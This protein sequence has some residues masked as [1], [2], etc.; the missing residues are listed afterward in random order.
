MVDVTSVLSALVALAAAFS[1]MTGLFV[2]EGF[3]RNKL[4][5]LFDDTSYLIFFF[6]VSGYF[7]YGLGEV[8]Y[9]LISSVLSEAGYFGVQDL[10]WLGGGIMILLSFI[11]LS[12]TFAKRNMRW[13]KFM[14][15][16]LV[17]V[18]LAAVVSLATMGDTFSFSNMYPLI[19]SLIVT[20]ALGSFLFDQQLGDLSLPLKIFFFASLFILLADIFYSSGATLLANDLGT[21]IS[22]L[23]YLAG[24]VLSGTAF[25]TL[26]KRWHSLANGN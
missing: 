14:I 5:D 17:G 24:Y 15:L 6:L 9:Y 12:A 16:L 7:F 3:F 11:F 4:K 19:S 25:L 21:L 1:A 10:Y 8:L 2:L 18:V 22:D 26:R 23:L 13:G 20:F